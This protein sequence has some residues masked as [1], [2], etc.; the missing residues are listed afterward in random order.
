MLFDLGNLEAAIGRL[1][2]ARGCTLLQISP[3]Y[4]TEPVG[5]VP[6]GWFLNAV[7]ACRVQLDPHELLRAAKRIERALGRT[8]GQRW[9]PRVIDID[10]LL[11]GEERIST[12]DLTVPHPELWNRRFVLAPLLDLLPGGKLAEQVGERLEVLPERPAVRLYEGQATVL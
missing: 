10:V 6:Q 2:R 5:P 4:E 12:D 8:P 9:G 1:R 11:Y 7:V 3:I